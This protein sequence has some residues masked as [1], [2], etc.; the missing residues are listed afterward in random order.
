MRSFNS[1]S[2]CIGNIV[3]LCVTTCIDGCVVCVRAVWPHTTWGSARRTPSSVRRVFMRGVAVGALI[4]LV[5]SGCPDDGGGTTNGGAIGAEYTCENGTAKSGAPAGGTDVVA[6]QRC[7]DGYTLMGAAGVD[8]TPCVVDSDTT[9]P[10]FTE[11]PAL[12]GDPTANGV[13]VTLTAS[14][15][16]TLFWVLYAGS[17]ASPDT[18]AV[19]MKDASDDSSAGVQRSGTFV[20]VTTDEKT[21]PLSQL[22]PATPYNFYAVLKDSAGNTGKVS[23]KIEI[24]TVAAPKPD[25]TVAV[26]AAPTG[27][28]L[29]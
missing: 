8:G 28:Y 20:K 21:I 2:Q 14:E 12:N 18:A 22:T 5:V 6:C 24:T 19:L 4:A 17:D 15:V 25:F 27:H 7:N 9:A 13:T 10:T 3:I 11:S 16:G 29:W 1:I 23:A 26:T